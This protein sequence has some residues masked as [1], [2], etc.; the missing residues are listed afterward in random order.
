MPAPK[1][2]IEDFMP[3]AKALAR[4][5]AD[6]QQQYEDL[7]GAALLGLVVAFTGWDGKRDFPPYAL[8]SVKGYILNELERNAPD[9]AMSWDD[10][11]DTMVELWDR[12]N[13][14]KDVEDRAT[15][16]RGLQGC[17]PLQAQILL[18]YRG[19]GLTQNQIATMY[20]IRQ[21][22]VQAHIAK[23]EENFRRAVQNTAP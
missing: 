22:T 10:V 23:A 7:E 14:A 16:R 6:D 1:V 19:L 5:Y 4:T 18:D 9:P 15:I 3:W 8:P 2:K 13:V 20:G 11:S 21:Q 17:T 12:S